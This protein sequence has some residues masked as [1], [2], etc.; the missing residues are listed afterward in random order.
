M[1]PC[2]CGI[3]YL[4][5]SYNEF[6]MHIAKVNTIAKTD[7][8]GLLFESQQKIEKNHVLVFN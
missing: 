1:S 7:R 6:Q 4:K 2:K 3:K 8:K 5:V